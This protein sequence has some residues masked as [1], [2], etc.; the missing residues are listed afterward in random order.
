MR[1]ALRKHRDLIMRTRQYWALIKKFIPKSYH[2]LQLAF[3]FT[4]YKDYKTYQ[5]GVSNPG[6]ILIGLQFADRFP[7]KE[8]IVFMIGHELGHHVL[9]HMT[10]DR[11]TVPG[12][13]QDCDMFGL[14]CCDMLNCNRQNVLKSAREFERW[15]SRS[16]DR[17]HKKTHGLA[18]ERMIRL[19]DHIDMLDENDEEASKI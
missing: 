3:A 8:S 2:E 15:R 5:G 9:G 1:L 16:L 14:F 18:K 10:L 17:K 13:E 19:S 6:T 7:D 11:A 4:E 12:E